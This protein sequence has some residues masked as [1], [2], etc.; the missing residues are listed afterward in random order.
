MLGSLLVDP[1][2]FALIAGQLHAG[3]FYRAQHE[4][5]FAA[6]AALVERGSRPDFVTVCDELGR[7]DTL[8]A[9]GGEAHVAEIVNAV[10]TAFHV[11]H[12]AEIVRDRSQLRGVIRA[13]SE[14][15]R[16]AYRPDAVAADVLEAAQ[17]EI[18]AVAER[19]AAG[20]VVPIAEAMAAV[21]DR[22]ERLAQGDQTLR[23][24]P[25]GLVGLD[26]VLG[27]LQ[28]EQL[29]IV[30]ARTGVG[31]SALLLQVALNAA[32]RDT[33]VGI[34]TLEMSAEELARR[35]ASHVAK[36]DSRLLRD[37]GLS[38]SQGAH[39]VRA[40]ETVAGLPIYL[41]HAPSLSA[42]ELVGRSRRM[43]AR[44]HLGLLIVDY[45]QLVGGARR[46][47]ET[48]EQEV[49]E[50]SRTLKAIARELQ[51]PVLAAAQLSR[52]A[53]NHEG[54]PRLADLRESGAIEQDADVV[55]MMWPVE[56]EVGTPA[57]A[58]LRIVVQKSR[59]GPTGRTGMWFEKSWGRFRSV[60]QP[61]SA[62]ADD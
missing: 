61:V 34:V 30:A 62:G 47:G 53:E 44:W 29:V 8:D 23:G 49:S 40:M 48:R 24:L 21:A 16:L 15:V 55:M 36:I 18:F 51:I 3:D 6:I 14:A 39:T 42:L 27:G 54:P 37:G 22:I 59:A 1:D 41:D 5:V 10:P 58:N 2:A 7:R 9:A 57:A 35:A 45:L 11:E 43:C 4:A 32:Q 19:G 38:E 25:T 52:A 26:R 46:R 12:Y 33:P 31:K 28:R 20:E 50:V 13:A 56:P 17:R 60:G